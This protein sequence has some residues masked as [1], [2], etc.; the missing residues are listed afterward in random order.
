MRSA[1]EANE[2]DIVRKLGVNFVLIHSQANAFRA[3]AQRSSAKSSSISSS[4]DF[5]SSLSPSSIL[6]EA[7]SALCFCSGIAPMWCGPTSRR[8]MLQ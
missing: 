2:H 7:T 8:E 3:E 4:S 6:L 5:S 1:L